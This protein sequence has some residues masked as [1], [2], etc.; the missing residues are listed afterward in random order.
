MFGGTETVASAIE[1][2]MVEMTHCPDDLRRLQQEHTYAV[3]LDQN[4]DETDLDKLPFLKCVIK[5]TLRL[6]P[7]IPLLNHENTEDCV[8]GGYSVPRGSRVM[9]NVFALGRDAGAWKDADVFRPSRFMV[10]EGEAAEVDFKGGCFEFLPFGPFGSGRRL[11]CTRWSSL[12]RSSLMCSTG[13]FPTAWCHRSSTCVMSSASLFHAPPGSASCP[14]LDSPALWSLMMMPR[15]RHDVMRA[16]IVFV[17]DTARVWWLSL[18]LL[19]PSIFYTTEHD[20]SIFNA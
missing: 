12:S 5:E 17:C 6:H 2:A 19:S 1:W 8:G 9:I 15:T 10:G 7:P 11:A 4:V 18:C 20:N 16:P 14:C 3:G 13:H